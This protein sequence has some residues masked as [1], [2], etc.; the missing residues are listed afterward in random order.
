MID[1]KRC[2]TRLSIKSKHIVN[3]FRSVKEGDRV[4]GDVIGWIGTQMRD[5]EYLCEEALEKIDR[6]FPILQAG[7]IRMDKNTLYELHTDLHR[8]VSINMLFNPGNSKSI[9][10]EKTSYSHNQYHY[11]EMPYEEHTMYV[12]NNQQPH[13]VINF[14]SYRYLFTVN[15]YQTKKELTYDILR[16][17]CIK[18]GLADG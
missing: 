16:N 3:N 2:Y 12:F 14:D 1:P 9:F 17:W 7:V 13:T 4:W 6:E 5:K 11:L 8:G 18:N 10:C 15:F